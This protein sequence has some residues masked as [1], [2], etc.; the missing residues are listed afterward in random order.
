MA[1]FTLKERGGEVRIGRGKAVRDLLA[2]SIF[3]DFKSLK[4]LHPRCFW[5]EVALENLCR[6]PV[7]VIS[8]MVKVVVCV[9]NHL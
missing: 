5:K 1:S 9:M 4:H 8:F 7:T 6:K 3:H 2:A